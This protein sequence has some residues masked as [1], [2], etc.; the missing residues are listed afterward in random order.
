MIIYQCSNC[1]MDTGLTEL[2]EPV[3]RYCENPG[4]M[5]LIS[6]EKITPEV[7]ANRLKKIADR[8]FSNLQSAFENMTDED[9]ANFPGEEDAE[10]Q[11]YL[12]LDKTKKFK[13]KIHALELKDPKKKSV[14][15]KKSASAKKKVITVKK[16]TA[17]KK[18]GK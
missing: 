6:K 4:E 3:C 10:K 11:M 15:K 14:K 5:K 1:K 12:L 16:K 17:G 2:Q 18:K 8:M 7:M 9:K 13:E